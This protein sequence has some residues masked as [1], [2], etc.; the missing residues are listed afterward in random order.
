MIHSFVFSHFKINQTVTQKKNTHSSIFV[1]IHRIDDRCLIQPTFT[2]SPSWGSF[3][4]TNAPALRLE[5]INPVEVPT[6]SRQRQPPWKQREA[7]G[8]RSQSRPHACNLLCEWL[9][10]EA[11]SLYPGIITGNG[12]SNCDW[13]R[14]PATSDRS[15]WGY[16]PQPILGTPTGVPPSYRSVDAFAGG[17]ALLKSYW[18]IEVL[19]KKKKKKIEME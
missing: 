3:T 8:P 14:E 11:V 6:T 12:M 1:N 17:N 16:L 7:A 2:F 19:T 13:L 4:P 18:T 10:L 15:Q 5:V 9:A